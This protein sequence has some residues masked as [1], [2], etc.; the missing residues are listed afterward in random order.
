MGLI[1]R[2][3]SRTYRT[4]PHRFEGLSSN[5][6]DK[7]RLDK[8]FKNQN[9]YSQ[10]PEYAYRQT[11]IYSDL[12]QPA[13]PPPTASNTVVDMTS[14]YSQST[15]QSSRDSYPR[16]RRTP[17]ADPYAIPNSQKNRASPD[18]Y[19]VSNAQKSRQEPRTRSRSP[20]RH[21]DAPPP[22]Q[23]YTPAPMSTDY[24]TAAPTVASSAPPAAFAFEGIDQLFRDYKVQSIYELRE[25]LERSVENRSLRLANENLKNIYLTMVSSVQGSTF[26]EVQKLCTSNIQLQDE[27]ARL[28]AAGASTATANTSDLE[29]KV[30]TLQ[31]DLSDEVLAKKD[32]R[33][34]LDKTKDERDS[35]KRKLDDYRR[36][37]NRATDDLKQERRKTARLIEDNDK[38]KR[39]KAEVKTEPLDKRL[40]KL[41]TWKD[42]FEKDALANSKKA[43][44]LEKE[45]D[46]LKA[47]NLQLKKELDLH[48]SQMKA[49]EHLKKFDKGQEAGENAQEGAWYSFDIPSDDET[50]YTGPEKTKVPKLGK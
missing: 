3:S 7:R 26:Q 1:S 15:T 10:Q 39:V 48:A 27:I 30:S 21:S 22:M 14:Y 44:H 24:V 29:R 33:R 49:M 37:F 20:R 32:I 18:P 42:K 4:K 35:L 36:D 6:L 28:K 34:D 41:K 8:E 45:N 25:R 12:K 23:S 5:I 9:M 2:V 16:S 46:H 47:R 11:D 38:L 50:M 40:E 31:R 43:T 13:V 17:D 19:G